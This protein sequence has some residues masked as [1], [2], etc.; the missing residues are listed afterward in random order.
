MEWEI[1]SMGAPF[2]V[3]AKGSQRIISPFELGTE[4]RFSLMEGKY[5]TGFQY[6]FSKW[7]RQTDYP[8]RDFGY[9]E[10]FQAFQSVNDYN[11]S[12]QKTFRPF[13]GLALGM[14]EVIVY[15]RAYYSTGMSATLSPRLGIEFFK[16]GRAT[17]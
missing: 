12:P 15:N 13:V 11:F 6:I 3:S 2:G 7:H 9:N 16:Y 10:F 5:S 1:L 17:L 14:S 8:Q 4:L